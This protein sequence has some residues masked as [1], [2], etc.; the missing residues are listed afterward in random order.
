MH[1]GMAH[2]HVQQ[3]RGCTLGAAAR[4]GRVR[5]RGEGLAGRVDGG[6]ARQL[7]VQ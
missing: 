1:H 2:R 7:A 6:A 5:V 3:A 4:L